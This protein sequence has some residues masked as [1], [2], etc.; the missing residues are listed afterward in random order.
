MPLLLLDPLWPYATILTAVLLQ[1]FPLILSQHLTYQVSDTVFK[2][3]SVTAYL[4][5]EMSAT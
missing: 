4:H 2:S 5:T 3:L 1:F